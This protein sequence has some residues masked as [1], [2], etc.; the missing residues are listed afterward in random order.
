MWLWQSRDAL[1]QR[2]S[3]INWLS[4]RDSDCRSGIGGTPTTPARMQQKLR[5]SGRRRGE[6]A[7]RRSTR[8]LCYL[9]GP[10]YFRR[11]ERSAD[12]HNA[13]S[14]NVRRLKGEDARGWRRNTLQDESQRKLITTLERHAGAWL[15]TRLLRAY[16]RAAR[17]V[18]EK[19]LHAVIDKQPI[20][21]F[22]WAEGYVNELDSLHTQ[23]R[24]AY[25]RPPDPF[26]LAGVR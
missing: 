12:A 25:S 23:P 10:G 16:L 13:P 17:R 21:F 6:R 1:S 4:R 7:A 26:L 24:N 11:F 3:S 9:Q 5:P 8:T 19:P 15:R 2:N 20:D 14:T 18:M 22:A